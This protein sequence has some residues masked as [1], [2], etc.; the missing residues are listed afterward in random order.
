MCTVLLTSSSD[1]I[2][3]GYFHLVLVASLLNQN[4]L[5]NVK[6]MQLNFSTTELH[7]LITNSCDRG[8]LLLTLVTEAAY[9]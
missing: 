2:K 6:Y 3:S 8:S 1:T 7:K 9:Y 4:Q 5:L